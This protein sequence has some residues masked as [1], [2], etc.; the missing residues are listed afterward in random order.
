[1]RENR[2]AEQQ[3][4]RRDRAQVDGHGVVGETA[5]QQI[6][7]LLLVE[8]PFRVLPGLDRR[9]QFRG[10]A[11]AVCPGEEVAD[12]VAAGVSCGQ[13]AVQDRLVELAQGK[14]L[15]VEPAQQGEHGGDAGAQVGTG[16]GRLSPN[17]GPAAGPAQQ[18]P[19]RERPDQPRVLSR[20][21]GQDGVQPRRQAFEI[22]VP[23]GQDTRGHQQLAHVELVPAGRQ[24]VEQF[25]RQRL[26]AGSKLGEQPGVRAFRRPA[27]QAA[28][29]HGP[30]ESAINRFQLCGDL[31]VRAG[32]QI[33]QHH[34][35]GAVRA[36]AA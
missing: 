22:V 14:V 7:P 16:Q 6:P 1:M 35:Q 25:V 11:T 5:A 27:D 4:Q 30:R 17:R 20:R 23:F 15:F 9:D 19:V 29:V 10:Q 33:T 21:G 2:Q 32:Q 31:P 26:T 18:E 28:R 3:H 24:P 8:D 34:L 36:P 13:P 12:G